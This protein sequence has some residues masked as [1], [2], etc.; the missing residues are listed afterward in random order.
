MKKCSNCSKEKSL[1]E[2]GKL[3]K[4]PDGLN[5]YCKFCESIRH[6]E[7]RIKYP[8]KYIYKEIKNRA[9]KNGIPFNLES[10]DIIIPKICPVFKKPFIFGSMKQRDWSVSIDRVDNTKGY[11]KGNIIIVSWRANRIKSDASKKE[12]KILSDF[13]N[14]LETK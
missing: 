7:K 5:Y 14:N 1:N 12:L 10:K 3:N 9:K 13:Y 2:F 11:V 6:R 8:E 4:S